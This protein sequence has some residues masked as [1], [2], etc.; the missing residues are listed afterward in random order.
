[1]YTYLVKMILYLLIKPKNSNITTKKLI[2]FL[3]CSCNFPFLVFSV[4]VAFHDII[5]AFHE[6]LSKPCFV[7]KPY[8]YNQL[9]PSTYCRA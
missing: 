4:A 7:A 2:N 6:S 1:M 9:R 3:A 5:T 8:M